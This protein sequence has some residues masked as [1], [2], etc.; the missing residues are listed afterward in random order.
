MV[1]GPILFLLFIN[2]LSNTISSNIKL[3]ADDCVL[4][5]NVN[6]V[7]DHHD[8]QNDLSRLASRAET[9]QMSFATKKCMKMTITLK[10]IPSMFLY[11]LWND[12]LEGGLVPEVP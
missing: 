9:R 6:S 8:L 5:R 1:L 11:R 10:K 12:L 4:Y 7:K 3:F 2:D